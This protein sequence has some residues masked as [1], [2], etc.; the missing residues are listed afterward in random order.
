LEYVL[1]A[2]E[3]GTDDVVATWIG[4]EAMWEVTGYP[5]FECSRH[6]PVISIASMESGSEF[7]GDCAALPYWECPVGLG[8]RLSELVGLETT[9]YGVHVVESMERTEKEN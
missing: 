5:K 9:G 7:S 6:D 3:I 1:V 4:F 2:L 8:Y